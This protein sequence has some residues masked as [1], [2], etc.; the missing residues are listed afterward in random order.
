MRRPTIA[1]IAQDEQQFRKKEETIELQVV[2]PNGEVHSIV[3]GTSTPLPTFKKIAWNKIKKNDRNPI[4][5]YSFKVTGTSYV[6]IV[7]LFVCLFV[8]CLF[9]CL[10]VKY[11]L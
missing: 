8:V 4:L 10:F 2:L 9:V 3:C 1:Y 6:S 11:S 7:C 5:G